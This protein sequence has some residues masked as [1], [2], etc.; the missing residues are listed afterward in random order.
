VRLTKMF[1][2][3][4]ITAMATMAFVGSGSAMA[5]TSTALCKVASNPCPAASI[6]PEGTRIEGLAENPTLLG[7]FFKIDVSIVCE[8]SVVSGT[9]STAGGLGSPLNGVIENLAFTGNCKDS[10]G[11]TC[12]VA[13]NLGTLDLLRTGANV[14]TATSLGN[15]AAVVC[16]GGLITVECVFSGE[17]KLAAV[18]TT[19]K[20]AE[21]TASKAVLVAVSGPKCPD[22]P[23]WDALYKIVAPTTSIFINE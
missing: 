10:S 2:P 18:G 22:E 4:A 14:G 16:K 13:T 3:A 12:G 8:H 11:G 23:R 17:P 20:A 7:K 21:L 9:I 19:E 5:N 6:Y 1:G 15:E